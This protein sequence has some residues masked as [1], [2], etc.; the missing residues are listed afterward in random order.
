MCLMV[1]WELS[2]KCEIDF[3]YNY[4]KEVLDKVRLSTNGNGDN[5]MVNS[6]RTSKKLKHKG[7][8]VT[9]IDHILQHWTILDF[10][11]LWDQYIKKNKEKQAEYV[12]PA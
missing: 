5:L 10:A 9:V 3:A 2:F 8:D 7:R 4:N 11:V 6:I 12:L 1:Y